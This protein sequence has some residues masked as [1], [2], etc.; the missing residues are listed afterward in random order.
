MNTTDENME[1]EEIT[2]PF[3]KGS[4]VELAKIRY[5]DKEGNTT[6]IR[7]ED[8]AVR[9]A[10]DQATN[11]MNRII[12]IVKKIKAYIALTYTVMGNIESAFSEVSAFG[13]SA[14]NVT[15]TEMWTYTGSGM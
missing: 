5:T 13:V 1:S 9:E 14:S 12:M 10:I 2:I 7:E 4:I 15:P 3:I 6:T 11:E 8:P